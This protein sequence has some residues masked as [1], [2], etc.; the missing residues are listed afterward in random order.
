MSSTTLWVRNAAY[1]NMPNSVNT[2]FNCESLKYA[3]REGGGR[4]VSGWVL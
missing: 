3:E 4:E 2:S 1:D